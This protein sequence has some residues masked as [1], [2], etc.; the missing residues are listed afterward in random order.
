VT[1]K[2]SQK[3]NGWILFKREVFQ[4]PALV[5]E[6]PAD[7]YKR[8]LQDAKKRYSDP[9]IK[10]VYSLRAKTMNKLKKKTS[11]ESSGAKPNSVLELV[12][13]TTG[14]DCGRVGPWGIADTEFPVSR[15]TL[16][17]QLKQKGFVKGNNKKFCDASLQVGRVVLIKS[18]FISFFHVLS[19]ILSH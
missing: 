14:V 15:N 8:L 2:E 13:N 10:Q 9:G 17:N 19:I 4:Q 16:H 11:A 1:S 6:T 18:R 7:R 5:G 3:L 12:S